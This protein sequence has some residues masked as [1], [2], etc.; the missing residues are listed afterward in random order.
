VTRIVWN[1]LALQH[2]FRDPTGPIGRDLKRRA[3]NVESAAKLN[4]SGRPGPNVDTGRLRSSITHE[5]TQGPT[6]LVARIGSN[7]EYARYV[8]EGTLGTM[9]PEIR[10][11]S[12][13]AL[14]WAGAEHPVAVIYNHPGAPAYPYLAPALEAARL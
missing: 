11:R 8:E 12:K 6:G 7:V 14:F 2:M 9:P 5:I 1:D 10:P 4:A 3:I 13:R